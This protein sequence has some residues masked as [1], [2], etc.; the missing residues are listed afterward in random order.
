VQLHLLERHVLALLAANELR[1][2]VLVARLQGKNIL[3]SV[4]LS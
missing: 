1:N 2:P 4:L 3:M